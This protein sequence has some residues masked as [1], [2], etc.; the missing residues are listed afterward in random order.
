MPSTPDT[1]RG[2]F[3]WH[4]LMTTDTKSAAAFFAKVAGWKT[5]AWDQSPA[6]TM[7]MAGK[8]PRAGL[9]LLPDEARAM[10]ARPHW[11]SYIGAPDVDATAREAKALGATVLKEA[12]EVPGE[13]RFVVLRDPQGAVFAAF[14]PHRSRPPGGPASGLGDF[15]WH[16][17]ATSDWRAAFEFYQRLFG[18]EK[19]DAM[20]MGPE[21]GTYQMYGWKGKTLGGMFT[22]P[23]SMPGPPFWLP[24]I[25]VADSKNVAAMVP[26]AG[27]QVISG[28]IEVPGGDWI[29]QGMDGQGA[30][31]AVH[32]SKPAVK[33]AAAA[34]KAAASKPPKKR[35][36]PRKKKPARKGKPARRTAASRRPMKKARRRR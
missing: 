36:A 35:A 29:A 15:S 34:K 22:K 21:V 6:Y 10:G 16:E 18:W 17:L 14:T 25:K 11:L 26:A 24:Y 20:E 8:Q 1:V 33:P 13:G 19:T 9:M 27:G 3:V 12:T 32:S 28:P 4:E 30:V 23:A 31:F 2:R 5:Q 7:F